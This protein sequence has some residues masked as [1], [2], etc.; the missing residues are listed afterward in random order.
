MTYSQRHTNFEVNLK[1]QNRIRSIGLTHHRQLTRYYRMHIHNQ[2]IH[3]KL[4]FEL[5][6]KNKNEGNE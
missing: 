1:D 3:D 5:M 6:G 4:T 2:R